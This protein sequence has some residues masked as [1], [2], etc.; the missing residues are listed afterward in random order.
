MLFFSSKN[1]LF[2]KPFYDKTHTQAHPVKKSFFLFSRKQITLLEGEAK[3]LKMKLKLFRRLCIEGT[4][5]SAKT[6]RHLTSKYCP[7]FS[8][9]RFGKI[10]IMLFQAKRTTLVL[11]SCLWSHALTA[12]AMSLSAHLSLRSEREEGEREELVWQADVLW[13]VE[14]LVML[15]YHQMH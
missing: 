12:K 2:L 13:L 11:W 15:S 1:Q 9:G 14:S 8:L 4:P 7:I 5:K 6:G 10:P 3:I